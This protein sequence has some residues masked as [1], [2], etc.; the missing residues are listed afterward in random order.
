[1]GEVVVGNSD[2]SGAHDSIHK[3]IG[4]V[5]ERAVV[6]P[7]MAGTKDRDRITIGHGPPPK[8]SG[9]AANH[10]IACGLAVMDVDAMDDDVGDI[11]D[12][13]ARAIGNV[14]IDATPINGL[15]A[16]H[17]E[18]LLEFD[19]HIP[20]EHDPEG[21]VLDHR[22][23]EG[24]WPWVDSVI[25]AGIG[26]NV[27]ASITPANCIAPEANS[28]I[29]QPLAAFVPIWVAPPAV[30]DRIASA[31][32]KITKVPPSRAVTNAP[33]Q[34]TIYMRTNVIQ[35]TVESSIHD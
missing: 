13:E 27:E 12:G 30:V 28:A 20:L 24:A 14:D 19:H 8:V 6:D 29:S 1:M 2:G 17:N 25:I 16:V 32:R 9:R 15:E 3:P 4:A 31:A 34:S 22:M 23:P 10:G 11:L 35:I 18:F 33:A 7:H 26:D 5:G 21:P